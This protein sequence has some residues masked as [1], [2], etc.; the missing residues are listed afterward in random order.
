MMTSSIS[1]DSDS[2][3]LYRLTSGLSTPIDL[4][5]TAIDSLARDTFLVTTVPGLFRSE[6]GT[7]ASTTVKPP[8]GRAPFCSC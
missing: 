5:P 7:S 1:L 8:D 4:R 6:I 3:T 2:G